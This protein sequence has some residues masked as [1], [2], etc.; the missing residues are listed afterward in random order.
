MKIRSPQQEIKTIMVKRY[1]HQ[2]LTFNFSLI[3]PDKNYDLK[4]REKKLKLKLVQVLENLSQEDKVALLARAKNNGLEKI[5]KNEIKS[6][7]L[8]SEFQHERN[9]DCE[10]GFWIFRLSKNGRVVS[11]INRNLFYILAID[12]KFKL[13]DHG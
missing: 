6:L 8:H 2:R 5:S 13:Y 1:P 3:T 7:R 9:S 10:E 4:N 11:K 12:S